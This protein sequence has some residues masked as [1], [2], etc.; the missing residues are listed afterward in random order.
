MVTDVEEEADLKAEFKRM[1]KVLRDEK[2]VRIH[3]AGL[4]EDDGYKSLPTVWFDGD[5]NEV[6]RVFRI[7]RECGFPVRAIKRGW[8]FIYDYDEPDDIAWALVFYYPAY[9]MHC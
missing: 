1:I 8:H 7:A 4:K 9:P 2:G 3:S 6:F 5:E